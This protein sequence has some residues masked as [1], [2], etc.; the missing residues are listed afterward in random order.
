MT[1]ETTLWDGLDRV[2]FRTHVDG[3]IGQ[4][5]LLRVRFPADVPGALP[6]YQLSLIHI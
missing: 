2:Q 6:L 1:Q 5:T 3:S 4:D